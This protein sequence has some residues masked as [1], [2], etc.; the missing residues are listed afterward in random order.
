MKEQ[1]FATPLAIIALLLGGVITLSLGSIKAKDD[2][3]QKLKMPLAANTEINTA[4]K[5]AEQ[6]LTKSEIEGKEEV[7]K[8]T[9]DKNMLISSGLFKF[10]DNKVSYEFSIPKAGGEVTGTID[11]VCQ[12]APTGNFDGKEEGK[13]EGVFKAKCSTGPLNFINVDIEI[14]YSGTVSLKENKAYIIYETIKPTSGQ[15][16]SFNLYFKD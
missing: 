12:G 3:I 7:K 16:G 4:G 9:P 13:V 2:L 10:S 5:S 15:R 11:G 8:A 1:G 14:K 6:K